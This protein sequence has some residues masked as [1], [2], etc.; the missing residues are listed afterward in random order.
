MSTTGNSD[1]WQL[2]GE[3][4][5]TVVEETATHD[6][7]A[8]TLRVETRILRDKL[9]PLKTDEGKVSLL[10]TD[11][12]G[13][14]AVDRANGTNSFTLSPPDRRK[15]LRQ[16]GTY[17][18]DRYE[19]DL[20]SQENDE[21]DVTLVFVPAENR[22]DEPAI[23]E[24]LSGAFT[25]DAT[26][27]ATFENLNNEWHFGTRMGDIVTNRVDAELAG[28]GEDGVERFELTIRLT[29]EQTHALEAA[30]SL[31]NGVRI[32]Q[33]P[34]GKNVA[35]DDTNGTATITVDSPTDETIAD[36]EYAALEFESTRL[37]D[38]FQQVDLVLATT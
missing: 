12:G 9:R 23:D 33:I 13:F 24:Q 6:T 7:L 5:P 10:A 11:D 20:V 16:D 31:I 19:E 15:P 34:D 18:V 28:T 38:A 21:W 27:D 32:R 22:A 37:N 36:G 8:L 25:F 29:H 14:R 4:I 1:P 17:H 35:V 26:F 2:D 30:L 3:D